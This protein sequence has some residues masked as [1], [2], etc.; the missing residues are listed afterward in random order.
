MEQTFLINI[1][2]N[3]KL[4][5]IIIFSWYFY[6]LE[7]F[8]DKEW[9]RWRTGTW[10]MIKYWTSNSSRIVKI[11]QL[12]RRYCRKSRMYLIRGFWFMVESLFK[13]TLCIRTYKCSSLPIS[14]WIQKQWYKNEYNL[15]SCI[16]IASL[17]SFAF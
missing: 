17:I 2:L 13:C 12:V 9:F 15:Y 4:T 14:Y 6:M 7:K 10:W 3:L 16:L 8:W 5:D 1:L 11:G